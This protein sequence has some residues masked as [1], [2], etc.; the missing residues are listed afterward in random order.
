MSTWIPGYGHQREERTVLVV[1]VR[2]GYTVHRSSAGV[3]TITGV[4]GD[5]KIRREEDDGG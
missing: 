5:I 4:T 3:V 2:N 1:P